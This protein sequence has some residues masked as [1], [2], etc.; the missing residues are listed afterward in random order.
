MTQTLKHINTQFYPCT[1][2]YRVT[3]GQN[4]TSISLIHIYWYIVYIIVHEER[5]SHIQEVEMLDEL[6]I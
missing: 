4:D 2:K 3:C 5:L 6:K 1:H